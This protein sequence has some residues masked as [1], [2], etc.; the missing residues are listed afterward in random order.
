MPLGKCHYCGAPATR[1]WADLPAT[2]HCDDCHL[3]HEIGGNI[4]EIRPAVRA[5]TDPERVRRA[6]AWERELGRRKV[7]LKLL[8][9]KLRRLEAAR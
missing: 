3:V 7:V 2:Q 8:E 9:N 6:L 5:E 4:A 1:G